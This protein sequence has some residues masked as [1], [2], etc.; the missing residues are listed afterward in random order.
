MAALGSLGGEF[1]GAY[2][3]SSSGLVSGISALG[4]GSGAFHAFRTTDTDAL[5]D[6]GTLGGLHSAGLG[7]NSR[8]WVVGD[9]HVATGDAHAF[10]HDGTS[11]RDLGT[12]GG[13][14]SGALAINNTGSIAGYSYLADGA[15]SHAFI[16]SGGVMTDIGT[17]PGYMSSQ[18]LDIN[19]SGNVAGVVWGSGLA[20]RAAV[21]RQGQWIDIGSDVFISTVAN[22]LNDTGV[23]VGQGV[24]HQGDS[25]RALLFI[26][27]QVLDLNDLI[28]PVFSEHWDLWAAQSVNNLGQIVGSGFVDGVNHGFLLTRV[29]VPEP[30]TLSLLAATFAAFFVTRR[31]R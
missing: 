21:Y 14:Y 26:D 10:M 7:I 27:G 4:D 13:S 30:A 29:D 9:S 15:T 12:L 3:I 18:G 19:E 22:G 24:A 5:V 1:S 23:V 6:L 2:A 28:E 31:R 11:M 8:G 16:Y 20:N 25:P 17:L